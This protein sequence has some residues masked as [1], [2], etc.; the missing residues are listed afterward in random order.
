MKSL[1]RDLA[2]KYVSVIILMTVLAILTTACTP[3]TPTATQNTRPNILFIMSDDHSERAI[4]AYGSNLISTP[5]IDR[6]ADEGVIFRDSFVTNSICGPSRAIMLTGKHS[7]KNGFKN[8][9]DRF[10][11]EHSPDGYAYLVGHGAEATDEKP[12]FGNL[13]WISGDQVYMLRV[14]PSIENMNDAS[15]Y[16]FFDGHDRNGDA[17]WTNDFESIKP[18]VD[19]NNNCGCVT[20][21]YNAPLKK[22]LMCNN[23][24]DMVSAVLFLHFK[25]CLGLMGL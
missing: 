12:R 4:S 18:L 1:L 6:I 20:M 10:E 13:S 7:H 23:L 17:I 9:R 15:K 11:M 3:D 14:K 8:N 21:T 24:F 19:W 5:N 2:D 22:Y 16:E 25:S